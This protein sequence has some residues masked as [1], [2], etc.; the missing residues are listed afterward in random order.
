MESGSNSRARRFRASYSGMVIRTG[1][2]S[3]VSDDLTLTAEEADRAVEALLRRAR[4]TVK[5]SNEAK[6]KARGSQARAAGR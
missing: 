2:G 5:A 4:A 6:A 3:L 1:S